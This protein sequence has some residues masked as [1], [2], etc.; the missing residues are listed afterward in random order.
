MMDEVSIRRAHVADADQISA[1][2]AETLDVSNKPDYGAENIASVTA[3]FTPGKVAE[4]LV[5]R[6][7]LVAQLGGKII[8]AVNLKLTGLDSGVVS[9]FFVLPDQQGLG[10]GKKL[11]GALE[12]EAR[13]RSANMVLSLHASIAG[14]KFYLSQ[15]YIGHGDVWDGTQRTIRMTKTL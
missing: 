13:A 3:H 1:V 6:C 14:E 8:G 11:L 9:A 7:Y 5:E 10:V 4:L 2:I 15:G 12:V